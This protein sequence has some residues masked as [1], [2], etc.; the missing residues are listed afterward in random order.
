MKLYG[1]LFHEFVPGIDEY[2]GEVSRG[3]TCHHGVL[4]VTWRIGDDELASRCR[5]VAVGHI[6]GNTLFPFSAQ[7]IGE[8]AQVRVFEPFFAARAFDGLQLVFEN[9]LAVV[10]QAPDEGAFSVIHTASS[11]EA[12]E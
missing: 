5:K 8:Q 1:G 2:D 9:A 6:D 7:S 10:E 11:S 3:G 4:H 12:E